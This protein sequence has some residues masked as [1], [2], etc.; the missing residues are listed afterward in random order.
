MLLEKNKN[1]EKLIRK[2]LLKGYQKAVKNH[3]LMQ[4]FLQKSEQL[5]QKYIAKSGDEAIYRRNYCELKSFD[6][7]C[8]RY[9]YAEMDHL[10]LDGKSVQSWGVCYENKTLTIAHF[11]VEFL[12]VYNRMFYKIK[13]TKNTEMISDFVVDRDFIKSYDKDKFETYNIYDYIDFLIRHLFD[14]T[15]NNVMTELNMT[16]TDFSSNGYVGK[17]YSLK[18]NQDYELN[19][20]V[21]KNGKLYMQVIKTQEV[22]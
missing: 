11:T 1:M 5:R 12:D 16:W 18:I 4:E 8:K 14:K 19:Y 6:E 22:K 9:I 20:H 10:L 13:Q 7:F 3:K 17:L 15:L 21:K 2:S